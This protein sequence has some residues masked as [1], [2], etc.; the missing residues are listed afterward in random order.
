MIITIRD[1]D[2]NV[3]STVETEGP[4]RVTPG[5]GATIDIAPGSGRSPT[6]P[7]A[8]AATVAPTLRGGEAIA[9][10][11]RESPS[12]SAAAT[13]S[14]P[15]LTPSREPPEARNPKPL[16]AMS[17]MSL[18]TAPAVI[19]G[20]TSWTL[21]TLDH[22]GDI[23]QMEFNPDGSLL[24]TYGEDGAVRLWRSET[25][26]LARIFVGADSPSG[27]IAWS[28]DGAA[29][30]VAA[31]AK[32]KAWHAVTGKLISTIALIDGEAAS[33]A[34]SPDGK[35]FAVGQRPLN[36]P[37][38]PARQLCLYDIATGKLISD[39][40]RDDW[41]VERIAW[42][43]DSKR[44]L[45]TGETSPTWLVERDELSPHVMPGP[46]P[47]NPSLAWNEDGV[48]LAAGIRQVDG[49]PV[50]QLW[51][52]DTP[53]LLRT[54]ATE[55]EGE[56]VGWL[57]MSSDSRFVA[58]GCRDAIDGYPS[59]RAAY[60]YETATGNAVAHFDHSAWHPGRWVWPKEAA[61]VWLWE[62]EPRYA[63]SRDGK[64]LARC[65]SHLGGPM[66]F[67]TTTRAPVASR[68]AITDNTPGM[69][70]FR[71]GWSND[72]GTLAWRGEDGAIHFCAMQATSAPVAAPVP[73]TCF[74][75]IHPMCVTDLAWSHDDRFVLA[76]FE[77]FAR[78]DRY[79]PATGE[80]I[81]R[82]EMPNDSPTRI[83]APMFSK[84]PRHVAGRMNGNARVGVFD[85][86]ASEPRKVLDAIT[87]DIVTWSPDA[88]QLA[89]RNG[90]A[91]EIW[92]I[93]AN[94]CVRRFDGG[95]ASLVWSPDGS[96]FV[97]SGSGEATI[98]D[99]ASGNV[100]H[101]LDDPP[102]GPAKRWP[103]LAW[104]PDGR[105]IAGRGRMWDAET[106]EIIS[107]LPSAA[108]AGETGSPAWSPDGA[109]LAYLGPG[110]AVV[111]T[112]VGNGLRAVPPAA[113]AADVAPKVRH[114]TAQG[115]TLGGVKIQSV[116]ALKGRDSE[117]ARDVV[118]TG[119]IEP[120]ESRPVGADHS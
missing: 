119:A 68:P 86:D 101:S 81:S 80:L 30:A 100:L 106:G 79:S 104:S 37:E 97:L 51:R 2:G 23:Y 55:F 91:T 38:A 28:P 4:A 69:N 120:A 36:Q 58:A 44:L 67:A 22:R 99:A 41:N 42:S 93:E 118:A 18:V 34:W 14:R 78:I 60:V 33:L 82:H 76:S 85:F 64:H 53:K 74:P 7:A 35:T 12:R 29:I 109:T 46:F 15:D 111:I 83:W 103:R 77:Q 98:H 102:L 114:S 63:I 70:E 56:Q 47:W 43:P 95:R 52:A 26:E 27:G 96:R 19:E 107:R 117:V 48:P 61:P 6:E 31:G 65:G 71:A 90:E 45:V 89:V 113:D 92:D 88:K 57:A 1:R 25:G 40:H 21:E 59:E 39:R 9:S 20:V 75:H 11:D 13:L 115:E 116:V 54:F 16:P 10:G 72:A 17:G 66:V 108:L 87:D 105:R 3:V 84:D 50:G 110:R 73:P 24:A 32:I 62:Y 5:E 8:D 94:E 49:K 112:S